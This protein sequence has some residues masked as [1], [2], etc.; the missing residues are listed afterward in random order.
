MKSSIYCSVVA[1]ASCSVADFN[2]DVLLLYIKPLLCTDSEFL[3]LFLIFHLTH[4]SLETL[5]L[6]G[7]YCF[8]L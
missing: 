2:Q 7:L 3:S 4:L 8:L 5:R 6:A 1:S